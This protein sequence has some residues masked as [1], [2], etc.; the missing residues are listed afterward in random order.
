MAITVKHVRDI[1]KDA[2]PRH[3]YIGRANV[4]YRLAASP[5]ANPYRLTHEAERTPVLESFTAWFA[6]QLENDTRQLEEILRLTAIAST[7]DL[8]LYCW[9][10]TPQKPDTPCHGDVI[11]AE[12]ERRI[13]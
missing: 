8:S 6:C 1:P 7:G 12:I 13:S 3:V 9:C 4:R 5:L 11:R 2:S 10:K